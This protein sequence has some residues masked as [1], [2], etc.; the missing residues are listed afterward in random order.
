MKES[1]RVI[2]RITV[3]P[4]TKDNEP[5]PQTFYGGDEKG[6]TDYPTLELASKTK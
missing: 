4:E 3:K 1:I 2:A 6:Y 5:D